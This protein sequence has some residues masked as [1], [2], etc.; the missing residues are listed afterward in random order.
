MKK[1][2]RKRNENKEIKEGKRKMNEKKIVY[3]SNI[4]PL[5]N[6]FQSV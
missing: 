3:K 6:G 2:K 4:N 5:R 1:E